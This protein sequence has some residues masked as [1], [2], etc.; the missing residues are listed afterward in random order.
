MSD[1]KRTQKSTKGGKYN[2]D[3]IPYAIRLPDSLLSAAKERAGLIPL[4]RAIRR[5]VELWVEGKI[6]LEDYD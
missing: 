5:L 1:K 2:G 3:M 6:N 4:S